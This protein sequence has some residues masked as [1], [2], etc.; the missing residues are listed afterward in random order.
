MK[1]IRDQ[2][3][4]KNKHKKLQQKKEK[5]KNRYILI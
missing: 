4:R 3:R 2:M 1:R 5:I